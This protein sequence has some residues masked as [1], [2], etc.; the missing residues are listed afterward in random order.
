MELLER[1]PKNLRSLCVTVQTNVVKIIEPAVLRRYLV[2]STNSDKVLTAK[3]VNAD[4]RL[5]LIILMMMNTGVNQVD[6]SD[7]RHDQVN[8]TLGRIIRKRSKLENATENIPT[9]NYQLWPETFAI[10]KKHR[11]S[12][13]VRVLVGKNGMPL[14]TR[15][16]GGS[17]RNDSIRL[18]FNRFRNRLKM[19]SELPLKHI[20]KTSASIIADKYSEDLATLFLGDAPSTTAGKHYIAVSNDRLDECLSALRDHYKIGDV[21]NADGTLVCKT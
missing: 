5:R 8:W 17:S 11:S 2:G 9:A 6:V 19:E 13:P 12:D 3:Q 14:V 16:V 15:S 21:L 7:L 20:R 18:T 1:E 10:L 4:E